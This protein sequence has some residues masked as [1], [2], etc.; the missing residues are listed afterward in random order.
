MP[1]TSRA[2]S[3]DRGP[4][5]ADPV[6]HT[7]EPDE[8]TAALTVDP[9]QGLDEGAVAERL[10]RH[11]P[12]ALAEPAAVPLWRRILALLTEP[13]TV[14][15]IIAA[16]VSAVVSR[17]LKTPVVILAVVTFNAVLNLVQERRAGNSLKALQDMTVTMAR[18]RRGGQTELV[19]ARLVVP[20]DIVL[21]EAGDVVPAD[22]RLLEAA[23]LEVQEAALTGESTPVTKA[24][25][26][27]G[28]PES[29]LGDQTGMAFMSTAVTRGRGV[30]VVTATG[31][32]TQIGHVAGLL[33]TAGRSSSS[34]PRSRPSARRRTSPPTRRA[35]SPSTR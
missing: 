15:L 28:D 13:M 5:R 24:I 21:L 4:E 32:G 27:A 34:S 12:N 3:P 31:M 19:D 11:G 30:L 7:S 10:D 6:W 23:G 35:P 22:G 18:V 9:A 14:V 2:D 1:G 20:G 8:V 25:A 16:A 26:A 33:G 17:E 29:P